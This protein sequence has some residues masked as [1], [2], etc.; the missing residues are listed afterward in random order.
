MGRNWFEAHC[1]RHERPFWV[2]IGNPAKC[3]LCVKEEK[4][5]SLVIEAGT[6]TAEGGNTVIIKPGGEKEG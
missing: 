2:L 1:E 6:I 5:K 3:P 4:E